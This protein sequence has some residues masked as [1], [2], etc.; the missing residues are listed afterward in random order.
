MSQILIGK[1]AVLQIRRKDEN[2]ICIV[3]H[4]IETKDPRTV[5][6][7][8]SAIDNILR[9]IDSVK[10]GNELILK[11][12]LETKT[13]GI[14]PAAKKYLVIGIPTVARTGNEDYL[15]RALGAIAKQLPTDPSHELY[16]KILI[17]VVNAMP[18]GLLH[19]RFEEAKK[20]YSESA[21]YKNYFTFS[22][23]EEEPALHVVDPKPGVKDRGSANIPGC[24]VRKQTRDIV[25][26]IRK[27]IGIAEYYLF[28]EDD[29]QLCPNGFETV[30]HILNKANAYHPNWL[31]I[32]ASYGMN[33]IFLKDTDLQVFANYLEKHQ[34][35][36]PPDHLIVEWY[37]GETPE[38]KEYKKG[39]QESLESRKNIGVRYNL[40]NHLGISSTLR[41]E[42][43]TSF[44][45]CYDELLEPTVFKV[46]AFDPFQCPK[47]DI[48]PCDS[49]KG[50]IKDKFITFV[51][52]KFRL[53]YR[54]I[55][56]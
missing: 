51:W 34:S 20:Q 18:A 6:M 15:L 24:K 21:V 10:A 36:R 54:M 43:S 27:S 3:A 53:G 12:S 30:V 49:V 32:R 29:M 28:L 52:P 35:R 14:V 33:G 13:Q 41:P 19:A 48:W 9:R 17:V 38:A 37:A 5:I 16:N 39:P 1:T 31:G 22:V 11:P 46:E 42:K 40:F 2:S 55:P 7:R 26:V 47:D 50:E 56:A 25:S 4:D 45:V 8:F 44:P 23:L